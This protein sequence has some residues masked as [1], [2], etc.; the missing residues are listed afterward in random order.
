MKLTTR[1]QR[2]VVSA[3]RIRDEQLASTGT[4]C[5]VTRFASV[6]QMTE[7]FRNCSKAASSDLMTCSRTWRHN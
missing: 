2:P 5:E 3:V 1:E 6:E 4:D 7:P